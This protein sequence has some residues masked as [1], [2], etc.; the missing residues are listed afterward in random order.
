MMNE[1]E[2]K[3]LVRHL[4]KE[5][6]EALQRG[7]SKIQDNIVNQLLNLELALKEESFKKNIKE[8]NLNDEIEFE[9]EDDKV[10]RQEIIVKSFKNKIREIQHIC[11]ISQKEF[12]SVIRYS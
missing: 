4:K 8:I 6:I 3:K 5:Y 10:Y 7:N 2:L 1:K 9:Y 12:L 11:Q